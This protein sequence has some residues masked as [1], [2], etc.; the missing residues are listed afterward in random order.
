[1][2]PNKEA[3]KNR[4]DQLVFYAIDK[5]S[6]YALAMHSSTNNLEKISGLTLLSLGITKQGLAIMWLWIN[7]H[8]QPDAKPVAGD[9]ASKCETV[10]DVREAVHNNIQGGV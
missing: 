3:V 8:C 10:S 2:P 9:V 5:A 4:L 1:M 6:P 7:A